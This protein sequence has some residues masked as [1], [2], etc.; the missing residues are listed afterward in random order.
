M[1]FN[2]FVQGMPTDQNAMDIFSRRWAHAPFGPDMVARLRSAF[3]GDGRP[4][5][6][7][8][9][10]GTQGRL[11]GMSVLEC[12]P[13][14]GGH[15][16]SLEKAGAEVTAVEGNVEAYLKCL[17]V[18]EAMGLSSR[19]LLG[20]FIPLL[21][22]KLQ[23]YDMVF[24]SGVLYHMSDP[25]RLLKAVAESTDRAYFWTHYHD[26]SDP[27]RRV[28]EAVSSQ[29]VSATYYRVG[30]LGRVENERWW[31]G[32]E[33]SAC[34]MSRN[35]ILAA[36][37]HFGYSRVETLADAPYANNAPAHLTFVCSR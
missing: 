3:E 19:F 22:A 2:K 10:F 9:A 1:D 26:P 20:S 15:T 6:A 30:N 27:F 18:K 37:R 36:C 21:E 7:I 5:Q 13:L 23:R 25:L 12:G 16:Y 24:A 11:D 32:L 35:E 4:G 29:G 31:G 14:E 33:D 8:A 34:W 28:G 17:V